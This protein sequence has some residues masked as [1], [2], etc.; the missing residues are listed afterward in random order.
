MRRLLLALL[1]GGCGNGG[2]LQTALPTRQAVAIHVPGEIAVAQ[3]R[4]PPTEAAFHRMTREISAQLN[5][6]AAGFFL[7]IDEATSTPPS[8]HDASNE[9]WGPFLPTDS[10]TAMLAVQKVDDQRYNFFLGG[11][12]KDAPNSD[13]TG[14]LGGSTRTIDAFHSSGQLEVNFTTLHQ[15]DP[16]GH[17]A[18]GAIAFVHDNT[19]DP[20]TVGVHFGDFTDG[21]A[22]PFTATY[23]YAEHRDGAGHFQFNLR[24]NFDD[25]ANGVLEDVAFVSRWVGSGAGRA[26]VIAQNGDLPS[27]VHATECWDGNFQRVYYI[28]D[29]DASKSEGDL[30]ACALP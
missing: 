28:E 19:A 10:M 22:A 13:F 1:V 18:T 14:L 16:A 26:D 24:T 7:F 25:D 23:Q 11:K 2:S 27:V 9:Y 30:S 4:P 21:S 5:S 12:A 29:V 20:R 15:L 17:P 3:L 6:A 8:A